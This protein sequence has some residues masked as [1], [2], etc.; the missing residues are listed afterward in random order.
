MDDLDDGD[1]R[2]RTHSRAGGRRS[3]HTSAREEQ[4]ISFAALRER[5]AQ[6]DAPP[7]L[8][9]LGTGFGLAPAVRERADLALE[10]IRG[11]GDYNHLSVRAAA[12]IILDRLR[13]R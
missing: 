3:V 9:L 5:M 12:S 13:G 2:G 4:G 7:V 8:I 11:P 1:R 10:A 6:A